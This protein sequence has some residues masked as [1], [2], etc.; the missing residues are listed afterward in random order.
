M[1][2]AVDKDKDDFDF[3]KNNLDKRGL[4]FTLCNKKCIK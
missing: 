1:D 2:K 3:V 4:N